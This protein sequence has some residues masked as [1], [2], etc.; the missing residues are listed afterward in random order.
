V[1]KQS[2]SSSR[3]KTDCSQVVEGQRGYCIEQMEGFGPRAEETAPRDVEGGETNER[4]DDV[5]SL[6]V[7]EWTAQQAGAA[8]PDYAAHCLSLEE[9][10]RCSGVQQ[11][12]WHDSGNEAL[13]AGGQQGCT[14]VGEPAIHFCVW[15]MGAERSWANTAKWGS[16]QACLPLAKHEPGHGFFLVVSASA[17]E[18]AACGSDIPSTAALDPSGAGGSILALGGHVCWV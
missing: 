16:A 14:A 1:E 17:K 5:E 15:A 11:L 4:S 10:P 9:L 12:A 6:A 3:I 13:E 8:T 18:T 2:S 7:L